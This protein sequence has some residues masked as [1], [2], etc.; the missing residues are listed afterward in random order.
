[1]IDVRTRTC[2]QNGVIAF[3]LLI[4]IVV[5]PFLIGPLVKNE[6]Q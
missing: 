6:G 1:M 3:Y 2:F 4:L 5:L